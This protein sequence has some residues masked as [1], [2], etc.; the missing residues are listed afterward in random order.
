MKFSEIYKNK[1][2]PVIS[3]E[4]FPPKTSNGLEKLKATLIDLADLSPDFITVTYGAM[5]T[6]RERTVEIANYIKNQLKVDTACHLTC[7]GSSR[8]EIDS[9]LD[10]INGFGIKN[11]VALRGD[12]PKG[13]N[14]FVPSEDGYSYANELVEHIRNY[15]KKH[16]YPKFGIAIAGYPEKHLEAASF[17][18]DLKNLRKKVDAG[19]DVIITQLF[20]DNKHY[21][22]FV[23]KVRN[24]GIDVPVIP[25]LMPIL[26]TN[27][28]KKITTMCGTTIP[29]NLVNKLNNAGD[30]DA[31]A[32]EIGIEQCIEQSKELLKHGS[33]GIHFYVLNKSYHIKRILNSIICK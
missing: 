32:E 11:I 29:E 23:E 18:A 24:E 3:F 17:D 20:F 21:F 27:Q 1:K 13:G 6:T 22:Q 12:P 2:G 33:P 10:T 30:N 25:G 16:N 9:I 7:V 8:K 15:E 19:A 5:G 28:I 4:I 14:K 31:Y 26:S